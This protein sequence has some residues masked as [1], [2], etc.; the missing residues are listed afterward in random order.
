MI[1][2]VNSML[3]SNGGVLIYRDSRSFQGTPDPD[4]REKRDKECPE[5]SGGFHKLKM[6]PPLKD[7]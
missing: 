1:C 4:R 7:L 2:I 5:S 3:I 6:A